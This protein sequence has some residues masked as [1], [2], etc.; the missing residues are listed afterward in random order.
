MKTTYY[1]RE[2]LNKIKEELRHLE[3]KEMPLIAA[4]IAEASAKGDLS[5]NAEYHAAKHRQR[6]TSIRLNEL[7]K[8]IVNA[9]VLDPRQID[10]TQVSILTTVEIEDQDNGRMHTYLLVSEREADMKLG[11][12]SINSPLGQ[13]ILGKK[14]GE[15]VTIEMP[16]PH[17]PHKGAQQR[18]FKIRSIA[19]GHQ[20]KNG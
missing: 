1:T 17:I 2:G 11:K 15:L 16:S 13:G 3:E 10:T 18:T 9:V 20:K 7:K 4:Q 14:I 12:L 5:E 19:S 6:V 8:E